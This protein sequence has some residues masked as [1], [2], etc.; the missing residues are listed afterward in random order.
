MAGV[1]PT[2][3]RP[4]GTRGVDATLGSGAA[5]AS[6]PANQRPAERAQHDVLA[7]VDARKVERDDRWVPRPNDQANRPAALTATECEG[8]YRP[9]RLSAGLGHISG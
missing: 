7:T 1:A 9:F 5:G 4:R 6:W 2:L 8:V 3:S